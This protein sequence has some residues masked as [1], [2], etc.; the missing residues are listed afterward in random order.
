MGTSGRINESQNLTDRN[1]TMRH[2]SKVFITLMACFFSAFSVAGCADTESNEGAEASSADAARIVFFGD[3]IT[4]MGAQPG[5]YVRII[6]DSLRQRY[7]DRQIEVIGA[8][9][10]GNK[11]PDLQARL[12]RDVLA[13]NPTHVVIY[14]GIN[15]VWHAFEFDDLEGTDRETYEA[16]LREIIS[17]IDSAGA[18]VLLCTPSVI[19]ENPADT[20]AVNQQ[21][22]EYAEISRTVARDTG[23]RLCDLRQAFVE[24]LSEN[25]PDHAESGI[26]TTDGVHL[27]EAGNQF[28][29]RE[30][31]EALE[32]ML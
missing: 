25:N 19:G 17:R 4:E 20:S 9:I 18:E 8:G 21:L 31:I 14:I 5:G 1:P 22:S 27:N 7:P 16:G 6:E 10:S 12:E 28:V 30:I 13:H 11:V 32:G 15:D 24:H 29:A 3:S 23:A 26:L 2:N